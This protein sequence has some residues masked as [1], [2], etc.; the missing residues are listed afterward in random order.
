MVDLGVEVLNETKDSMFRFVRAFKNVKYGKHNKAI[1]IVESKG[2]IL[3]KQA[4][5]FGDNLYLRRVNHWEEMKE[6]DDLTEYWTTD[7]N[8]LPELLEEFLHIQS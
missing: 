1:F 7:G 2:E 6:I 8:I 3:S 5:F 4:N